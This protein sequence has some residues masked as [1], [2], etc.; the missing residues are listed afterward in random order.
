MASKLAAAK[1]AAWS[2]VRAVIAA[3]GR[4]RVL[5]DA[6]A[7]TAGVGT[8]VRPHDR[9]LPA[10]KLWIAFAVGAAGTIVVD[11]GAR[12]ALT[13][14]NRSLLPAGVVSVT[15][16]FEAGAAVEI[17]TPEGGVFAKGLARH[18]SS[19]ERPATNIQP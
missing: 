3:A 1:I 10:R 7:G 16:E 17:A 11:E 8:V 14:H 4:E 5:T 9:R 2:G 13:G 15:G 18:H 19:V 12:T 6:V